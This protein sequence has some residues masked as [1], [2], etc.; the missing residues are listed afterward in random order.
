V[1]PRLTRQLD[2]ILEVD[3]LKTV[4]R[5]TAL[6]DGSRRENSAEHSWHLSVMAPLL[7]EHAPHDVDLLRVM[8]MLVIHDVVEIDAGDTFAFDPAAHRDKAEREEAAAA[9]IFGLL[10]DDQ[11]AE[12][13]VL[14]DEF[15]ALETPEAR[16][17][18]AL[19]RL[20]GIVQNH[21]NGG[22]T[23]V[24]HQVSREAILARQAPIREAIPALWPWVVA[25]VDEA[26][27]GTD[28]ARS[29]AGAP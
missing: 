25:V 18:N 12:L 13:R 2:F 14:W 27:A 24:E 17:A 5:M 19:D 3:R 21:R 23:W 8:K 20:S 11:G 16:F 22:G 1:T 6:G 26:L 29:A 4:L 10:P 15:E 28:G 7:V 9:R